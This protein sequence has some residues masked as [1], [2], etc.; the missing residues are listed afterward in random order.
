MKV[1]TQTELINQYREALEQIRDF[2][3]APDAWIV[4]AEALD[5]PP[6]LSHNQSLSFTGQEIEMFTPFK[7]A[8][9]FIYHAQETELTGKTM[10]AL[11]A[12]TV[13]Y[14]SR[15]L[16]L[17]T[18][19]AIAEGKCDDAGLLAKNAINEVRLFES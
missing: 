11:V 18:L 7:I 15:S 13:I 12:L 6:I 8:H 1:K 14:K 2:P 16:Y 5:T 4:A 3:N 17:D 9:E 19:M 10:D